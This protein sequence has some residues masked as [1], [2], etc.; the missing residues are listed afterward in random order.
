MTLRR[1]NISDVRQL[2]H[3]LTVGELKEILY[4]MDDEAPVLFE[5][6]HDVYF[7]KHNWATVLSD[8]EQDCDDQYKDS[9]VPAESCFRLSGALFIRGHY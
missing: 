3:K 5:R 2:P 6:I 7:E 9:Y 4:K 1:T 8:P